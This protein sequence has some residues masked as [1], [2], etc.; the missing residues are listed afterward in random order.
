MPSIERGSTARSARRRAKEGALAAFVYS[1][2]TAF[3][4]V[5]RLTLQEDAIYTTSEEDLHEAFT[6]KF[7]N[8]G[9]YP[10]VNLESAMTGFGRYCLTFKVD[11][12]PKEVTIAGETMKSWAEDIDLKGKQTRVLNI[13]MKTFSYD[14][15][16]VGLRTPLAGGDPRLRN[17]GGRASDHRARDGRHHRAVR[18]QVRIPHGGRRGHVE[19]ECSGVGGAAEEGAHLNSAIYFP[20]IKV[21]MPWFL[22][23]LGFDDLRKFEYPEPFLTMDAVREIQSRNLEWL[24]VNKSLRF[25]KWEGDGGIPESL[26][27]RYPDR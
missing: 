27:Q 9:F 4:F 18:A 23:D 12:P 20:S 13:D 11:G 14:R 24:K 7:R 17:R 1:S 6:S 26:K 8:P 5:T 3:D 22:P 10:V 16:H 15:V 2:I 21:E 25:A 19:D